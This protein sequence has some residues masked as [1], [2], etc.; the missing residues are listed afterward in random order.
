MV[1][2]EGTENDLYLCEA[3][4]DLKWVPA[5]GF[6]DV[7]FSKYRWV[8]IDNNTDE[9]F[10]LEIGAE[11]AMLMPVAQ[12]L[13]VEELNQLTVEPVDVEMDELDVSSAE[14]ILKLTVPVH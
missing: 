7:M 9:A 4:P 13:T 1:C 3:L 10:D 6:I 14:A 8:H 11:V 2:P 5:E 12:E